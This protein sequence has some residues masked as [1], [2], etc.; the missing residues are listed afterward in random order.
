MQSFSTI[1]NNPLISKHGPKLALGLAILCLLFLVISTGLD[2]RKQAKIKAENYEAQP[3]TVLNKNKRPNY[4]INDVINANLFGDPAPKKVVEKAPKT[5]L[6]LTLHGIL[7]A[8]DSSI[9][10]AIISSS[11]SQKAELYSIDEKIN[12]A[13]A[14]IKEIRDQEVILNRNGSIESL[15]LKKAKSKGNN[16]VF[17]PVSNTARTNE[18]NNAQVEPSAR[19]TSNSQP[20]KIRKPTFSGLDRVPENTE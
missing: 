7:S 15:P 18:V 5:T 9:A 3:V 8:S 16:I 6:D 13:G 17:T 11:R 12:G 4:R 19:S 1:S 14:S 2:M 20:R 10:R